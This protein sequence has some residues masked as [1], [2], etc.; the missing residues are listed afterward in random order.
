[1]LRGALDRVAQSC[2]GFVVGGDEDVIRDEWDAGSGETATVTVRDG[3][4]IILSGV[5]GE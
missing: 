4:P 2:D 1:V 3:H 5:R